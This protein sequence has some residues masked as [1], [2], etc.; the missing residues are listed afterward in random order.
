MRRLAQ[1]KGNVGDPGV[2]TVDSWWCKKCYAHW[3]RSKHL[4]EGYEKKLKQ[5]V[6][7]QNRQLRH[8][9][10]MAER[11]LEMLKSGFLDEPLVVHPH[12]RHMPTS[13]DILRGVT[14]RQ[15]RSRPGVG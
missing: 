6:M 2:L 4:G 5:R 9:V 1:T 7:N 14:E 11:E 15:E 12:K 10:K 8:Q 13:F 3:Y